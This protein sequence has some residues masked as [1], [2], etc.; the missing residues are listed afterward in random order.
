MVASSGAEAH[1]NSDKVHNY[2]VGMCQKYTRESWEVGSLYGSAIDAWYGAREKH[3]G[4][5]NP[6][7]GA[8]CYYSGGN[9]GHAVVFQSYG[10]G[11]IRSTD[12][13]S[14]GQVNDTDLGWPERQWGYKYLGW[15]G[16]INGVD[17]PNLTKPGSGGGGDEDDMP[18]YDHAGA[19]KDVS[20]KAD[21][22]YAPVWSNVASGKAFTEG[23]NL[24]KLAGRD[25]SGNVHFQFDAPQG[26][27]I[28]M[29][30]VEVSDGNT[31]ESNPQVE[32]LASGGTSYTELNQI[33]HVADGRFLAVRVSCSQAAKL[34]HADATILSW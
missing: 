11:N 21:Q 15:T 23:S 8:P 5:R 22:W 9:Y 10:K 26:S 17:C 6:P 33:G 31:D 25:Y 27:T 24:I 12:C 28:R 14:S 4:D 29:R 19:S 30:F 7:Q 3:P 1:S 16:D 32:F 20:L 2:D 18:Q 13:P 34:L